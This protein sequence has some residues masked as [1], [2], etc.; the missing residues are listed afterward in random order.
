MTNLKTPY[1]YFGGKSKAA[2]AIWKALGN[3]KNYVE[4]F[5]GGASVLL[6]RPVYDPF[7]HT[8]TV[9]DL[10]SNLTNFW[11]AVQ[12]DPETLAHYVDTPVNEVDLAA[13]HEWLKHRTWGEGNLTARLRENP[14]YFDA[15]QA[16]WWV[17]GVCSSV[18]NYLEGPEETFNELPSLGNGG[19]GIHRKSPQLTG[20][21]PA[22]S[23]ENILGYLRA[24]Q[25]RT[26]KVRVANG[27]FERVLKY[28][29]TVSQ[30]L[31][32]VLLDP[33]YEGYGNLYTSK[34]EPSDRAR[35]WAI[36]NGDNPQFRIVLCGY[37]GEHRMPS[38]W[39]AYRWKARRGYA[40][41]ANARRDEEVLWLS[42]YC[43]TV[44][45]E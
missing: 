25:E 31:T 12:A 9:N 33:P 23:R 10:D 21:H 29:V 6:S 35:E 40:T 1:P 17:H 41:V 11:R 8:E 7:I 15:K 37:L 4:P 36:A 44:P 34:T 27:D 32:G 43:L 39:V 3:P 14:D 16:G 5:L 18:G 13:R 22:S 2:K 38:N 24:L 28:S 42:P 30:G 45:T 19:R 26:R 20:S